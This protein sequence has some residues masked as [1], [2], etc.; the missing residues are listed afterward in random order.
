MKAPRSLCA[1]VLLAVMSSSCGYALA[2]R[3]SYLPAYIK[4]VGIPAFVNATPY[5]EIE[6]PFTDKVRA[7]FIGR[8]GYQVLPQDIGVDAVLKGTIAGVGILPANFNNQQQATRYVIM[9][10]MS[11]QFIDVRSGKALWENPAM[12]FREEYDLPSDFQAGDP[13]AFLVQGANAL[14]RVSTDFARTVVSAILEA[15]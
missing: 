13:Q 5:F 12:T 1:V 3:G 10:T 4:V 8:G 2:G 11:I 14:Q 6:Q 7:E 9:I 15:F